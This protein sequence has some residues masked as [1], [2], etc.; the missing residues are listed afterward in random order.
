M[1]YPQRNSRVFGFAL[2]LPLLLVAPVISAQTPPGLE[3]V[4]EMEPVDEEELEQFVLAFV[5]VHELQ[6]NLNDMTAERIQESELSERR[7]FE[8]NEF[9]QQPDGSALASV[10]DDE[11]A[12]Y[13]TVLNDLFE[14]QNEQQAVMVEV[15]E[16]EDLTVDRFNRIMLALREDEELAARTEEQL[17]ETLEEQREEAE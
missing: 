8:I 12:E 10:A 16:E 3:P 14:I 1:T 17:Q 13:Q 5:E 11:L 4:D 6:E 15:V 9:A 2:I 7:F